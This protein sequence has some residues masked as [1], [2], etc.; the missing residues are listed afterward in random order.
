MAKKS[1]IARDEQRRR[2]VEK[3]ATRRRELKAVIADPS[4]HPEARARARTE[5]DR[6]P[7]DASATRL[8]N[9]GATTGRPRAHLRRFGLD[10]IA[11]REKALNGELP[12]VRKASW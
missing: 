3:Y 5:L 12:G 6:Q 4:A 1:K 9:R 8:R 2:T 7:R 10:R 11:F